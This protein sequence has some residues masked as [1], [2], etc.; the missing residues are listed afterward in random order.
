MSLTAAT[1]DNAPFDIKLNPDKYAAIGDLLNDAASGN[2]VGKPDVS[3]LLVQT[4]GDQGITGFLKLTGAV[5][6]AGSSDQLEFFEV[7]RR[8]KTYVYGSN[9]SIVS[10]EINILL[11]PHSG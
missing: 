4:Y 10:N 6:S 2:E 3:E 7:G 8:H 5:T 11:G 1:R 9:T